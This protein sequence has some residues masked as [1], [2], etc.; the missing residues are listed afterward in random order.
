MFM[1]A[2]FT[3]VLAG[4][5]S[6]G[7]RGRQLLSSP[8]WSAKAGPPGSGWTAGPARVLGVMVEA[9]EL[10]WACED[11][12]APCVAEYSAYLDSIDNAA[13]RHGDV[14]HVVECRAATCWSV[15]GT[16]WWPVRS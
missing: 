3:F 5:L 8:C 7:S 11:S 4:F 6:P 1:E 15:S 12:L 13:G 14:L 9:A 10:V 16:R 2:V